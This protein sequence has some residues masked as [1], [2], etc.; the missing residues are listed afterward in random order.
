MLCVNTGTDD[1]SGVITDVLEALN[2]VLAKILGPQR[3]AFT[4]S[5]LAHAD[6]AESPALCA[7]GDSLPS[8]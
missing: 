6:G 3:D 1:V 4:A 7:P 5:I 2:L 8:S